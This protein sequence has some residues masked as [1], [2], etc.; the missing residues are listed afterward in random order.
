M[1]LR[2]PDKIAM[3]WAEITR[4]QYQRDKLEYASD[5]RDAEWALI[6]PLMPEWKRLER[7]DVRICAASLSRPH[8]RAGLFLPLYPRGTMESHE[9]Y[10]GYPKFRVFGVMLG[11]GEAS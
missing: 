1:G 4:A 7:P 6:A 5:L 3:A 2:E 11:E 10:R 9:S 8:D